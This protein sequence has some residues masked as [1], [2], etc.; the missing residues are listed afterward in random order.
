MVAYKKSKLFQ[1]DLK[2]IRGVVNDTRDHYLAQGYEV[3]IEECSFGYFIS[4]TKGGIFKSILGMKSALNFEIECRPDGIF[5][6]AHIGIF[7]QQVMPSVGVMVSVWPFILSQIAGLVRQEGLDDD[8]LDVIE[9]A[10]NRHENR[11]FCVACGA[12]IAAGSDICP[13]CGEAQ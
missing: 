10:I 9:Q 1:T 5:V 7:G 3:N 4:M 2:D 13:V 12:S 11:E 8:V 6:N